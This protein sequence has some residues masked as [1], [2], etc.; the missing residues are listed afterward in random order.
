MITPIYYAYSLDNDDEFEY[1][2]EEYTVNGE[3][4]IYYDLMPAGEYYYSFC[5]DDIYG[6]YYLT[7]FTAFVIDEEGNI[8]F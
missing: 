2:G 3:V 8:L 4:E 7:D 1:V 6:D 5:I